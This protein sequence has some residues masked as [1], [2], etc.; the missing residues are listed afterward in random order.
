MLMMIGLTRSG[1]GTIARILEAIIGH[2]N[3]VGALASTMTKYDFGLE[4]LISKELCVFPDERLSSVNAKKFVDLLLRITGDDII[5]IS[6]KNKSAWSGHLPTRL[7]FMSNE[8]PTLPDAS[9]AIVG[10]MLLLD[11]PE[12]FLDREIEKFE[13]T[14]MAEIAGIVNWALDGLD[15]LSARGRFIKPASHEKLLSELRGSA[16]SQLLFA[17]EMCDLGPQEKTFEATE[18]LYKAWKHWC[19]VNGYSPGNRETFA[20]KLVAALGKKIDRCRRG[21]RSEQVWGYAGIALKPETR[22]TLGM[23][24]RHS[25]CSPGSWAVVR[26]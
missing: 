7:M 2:E 3:C 17:D 9:G 12:S 8:V 1:K 20:R 26:W 16:S 25:P 14:L 13:E 5:T 19:E 22:R 10:R 24:S 23:S 18:D 4:P 11:T 6:K 21:A 15:E